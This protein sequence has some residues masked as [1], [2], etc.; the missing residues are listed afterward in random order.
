M[1][2]RFKFMPVFFAIGAALLYALSFPISKLLL[3]KIP[4]TI[5][6][7]ILYIGAGAGLSI[8]SIIKRISLRDNHEENLSRGD[9]PYVLGMIILDIAAPILLMTGLRITTASN[10]ALLNNFEIVATSIIAMCIFNEKISNRLWL[11][12]IFITFSSMLLS[13]EDVSS[14]SFSIGSV[15]ILGACI[16]WGFENNCTKMISGKNPIH[17]V[18][19]KGYFSGAGSIIVGL[20][21]GQ[22]LEFNMY[23]IGALCLGFVSY[24]LS[25]TCYIYAQRKLGAAKTSAYYALSPFIGSTLSLIIFKETP[26]LLFLSAVVFMI[27]GVFFT[28]YDSFNIQ[29]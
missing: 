20:L 1:G 18:Q 15:F 24:G 14:F 26:S 23:I 8:I 4:E 9:I 21:L 19:I 7:G 27:P 22:R 10:A 2:K 29:Y 25:I 13:I 12:I 6:A 5:M 11:G 16:C 28:T 3:N 17:I